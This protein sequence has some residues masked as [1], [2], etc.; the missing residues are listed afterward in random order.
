[1]D[2]DSPAPGQPTAHAIRLPDGRDLAWSEWGPPDGRPVL[3][4]PGAGMSGVLGFGVDVLPGLGLR[5]LAVDRPGLGRSTHDPAKTYTSWAG[6]VGHLVR[7]EGLRRVLAVGFSQGAPFAVALAG[8]GLL[9]AVALVAGQD[10]LRAQRHLLV[11]EVAGMLDAVDADPDGFEREVAE[12]ADAAWLWQV[13]AATA[14]PRDR[15]LY[16]TTPL[17]AAVRTALEDGFRQGAAG[18]AR[19]LRVA[20]GPWPVRP[21]DIRTPVHLWYGAD[22]TST[23]HSPDRGHAL[24]RRIPGARLTVLDGEGGAL[25][26]TRPREVLTALAAV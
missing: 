5:L 2:T 17:G 18:Y 12:R 16:G 26:W 6:D 10:D 3:F 11:P 14:A 24:G 4:C 20:L 25:P 1:M 23:V 19:D 8:A 9:D 7:A 15:S 13:I 21:E 22:D